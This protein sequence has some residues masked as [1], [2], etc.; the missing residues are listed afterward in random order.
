MS[1]T[2]EN[3]RDTAVVD[4]LYSLVTVACRSETAGPIKRREARVHTLAKGPHCLTHP[5]TPV[6]T[7]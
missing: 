3:E 1:H 5:E 6:L 2:C 4:V 7:D